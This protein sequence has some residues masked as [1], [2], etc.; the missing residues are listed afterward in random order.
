VVTVFTCF[1]VKILCILST[2]FIYRF[3]LILIT[4]FLYFSEQ[5]QQNL[6]CNGENQLP[7]SF[8][9]T[10]QVPQC[11]K[12]QNASCTSHSSLKPKQG[13]MPRL[14]VS[15]ERSDRNAANACQSSKDQLQFRTAIRGRCCSC[16]RTQNEILVL[17]I[18]EVPESNLNQK[19][20]YPKQGVVWFAQLLQEFNE[21][22]P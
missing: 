15:S 7:S 18:P 19:V 10:R 9:L 4:I 13:S 3:R 21:I 11:K 12:T 14:H 22:V 2:E 20:V 5:N 17:R 1:N 8:V 16:D 6:L